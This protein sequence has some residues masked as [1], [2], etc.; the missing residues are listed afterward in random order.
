MRYNEMIRMLREDNDKSQTEIAAIL[1][2]GQRTY[3]DYES[4]KTRIP[5]DGLM[6]LAKYY[7]VDMDYI[8]GLAESNRG[9]PK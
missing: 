3:S 7:D 6:K 9:F 2:V 8:C 1:G 4:G 5:V